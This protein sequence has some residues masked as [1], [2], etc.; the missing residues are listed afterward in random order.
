MIRK[1]WRKVRIKGH[2]DEVLNTLKDIQ[3]E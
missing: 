3:T 2:I 1:E